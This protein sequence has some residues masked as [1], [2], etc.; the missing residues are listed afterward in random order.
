M[1]P[2]RRKARPRMSL[3]LLARSLASASAALSSS[4]GATL[5]SPPLREVHFQAANRKAGVFPWYCLLALARP[6]NQKII[7]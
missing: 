6:R 2:M 5:R 7:R 3:P 1:K 4:Q